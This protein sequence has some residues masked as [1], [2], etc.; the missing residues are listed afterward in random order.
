MFG[1]DLI[2]IGHRRKQYGK[3][4]HPRFTVYEQQAPVWI[5][6]IRGKKSWM[7]D[8]RER[9]TRASE[10]YRRGNGCV[11]VVSSITVFNYFEQSVSFYSYSS[12]YINKRCT[13]SFVNF[14]DRERK[15]RAIEFV[16]LIAGTSSGWIL[17]RCEKYTLEKLICVIKKSKKVDGKFYFYNWKIVLK[18]KWQNNTFE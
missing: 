9:V 11:A 2:L 6:R 7:G 17:F 3:Y 15:K 1:E 16:L 8:K 13:L 10:H 4:L 18:E 14:L 12:L 5:G